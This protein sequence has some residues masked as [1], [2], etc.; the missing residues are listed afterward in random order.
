MA[1]R[2][3]DKNPCRCCPKK[4]WSSSTQMDWQKP[5]WSH[6]WRQMRSALALGA[7][8]KAAANAPAAVA[9]IVIVRM[10]Y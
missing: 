10:V 9:M 5:A 8:T 4:T 1:G 6:T 2:G 7:I 3:E